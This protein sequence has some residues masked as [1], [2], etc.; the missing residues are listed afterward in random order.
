MIEVD[1]KKLMIPWFILLYL[2]GVLAC[3]FF[4]VTISILSFTK[5]FFLYLVFFTAGPYLI[6]LPFY[7]IETWT[8]NQNRIA[9]ARISYD[10]YFFS[11]AIQWGMCALWFPI[12]FPMQLWSFIHTGMFLYWPM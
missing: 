3:I 11:P 8:E 10:E 2:L 6:F 12:L 7:F 9:R 4:D 5:G 1:V